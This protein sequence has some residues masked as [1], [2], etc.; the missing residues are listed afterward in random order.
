MTRRSEAARDHGIDAAAMHSLLMH[1][2]RVHAIGGRDLRDLGDAI[3]LHDAVEQEPFWNRLEGLRWPDAPDAFDRRLT[4]ALVL[5][6]AIGRT[7][8]IWA[9]PLHDAPTD[10]VARLE[11]NG[12]RDLGASCV[13]LLT[14]PS[15]ATAA[16]RAEVPAAVTIER[17]SVVDPAAI[18]AAATDVDSVLLDAFEV[19]SDR[20]TGIEGETVASLDHPWFTHYLAR[21]DGVPAGVARRA[22][23]DGAS[24]LSSIG[25]AGWARGRGLGSLVT[26]T[27]VAD[28]IAAGSRWTYL[29]VFSDNR[30][31]IGIYERAGF[32]QLGGPAP[33]LLLV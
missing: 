17:M 6:A 27:A 5:F 32:S 2:A 31:A 29:G 7:P 18:E 23:F 20:R 12:F 24:Y 13:M 28:A 15:I 11:A 9:S 33:D 8:H 16:A 26:R 14:D 19:G 1:E 30:T 10:L 25:T 3:L 22:T 4:D 21:V